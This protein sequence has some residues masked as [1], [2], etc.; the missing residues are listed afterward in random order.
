VVTGR[1]TGQRDRAKRARGAGYGVW[2]P[3][4][5]QAGTGWHTEGETM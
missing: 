5:A 3:R 1:H 4:T 2:Q